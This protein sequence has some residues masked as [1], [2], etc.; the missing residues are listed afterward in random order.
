MS[1]AAS[2]PGD[3]W[4]G[5]ADD[6]RDDVEETVTA[7]LAGL[8]RARSR[9]LLA[10]LLR[11]HRGALFRVGLLVVVSQAAALA[12]PLLVRLGIDRGIPP[13][14]PG[15]GGDP[16]AL[17]VVVA[18]L[19][20]V[21]VIQAV[22]FRAFFFQSGRIGEDVVLSLRGRLYDHVGRLSLSFHERFTSGRVIARLT[23]DVE[24]LGELMQEGLQALVVAALSVVSIGA[25]LVVL[26]P[27]LGLISLAS[28]VPLFAATRWY[29][30]SA[31]RAYR[32]IREAVA[33]V[34]M[35]FVESL[36]GIR[37]VHAFRRE[38]RNQE[39]FSDLN[40]RYREA[41]AVSWRLA[42]VYGP[43]LK[44][45]GHLTTVAVLAY[46]AV[47]ATEGSITV[48]TLTAFLLYL[49]RY[50]DPMQD[51]SQFYTVFQSAAAA[52]EKISG[53]LEAEPA[54]GE[55][56]EPATLPRPA[57]GAT[58][59]AVTFESVGFAYRPGRPVLSGLDLT[60]P[61]G[62]TVALVGETGA[63]KS[64]VA[65]LL[66]RF[67]DPTAGR[68]TLDGVDLRRLADADLRRA[69]VIVTQEGFLFSGSVADNIAL[70]RPDVTRHDVEAAAIAVGA[71]RF[72]AA[73]PAGYDTPVGK[74]GGSLSAG[75]RQL[76]AFA[77]AFLAD[78]RVLILDEATSSLDLPTERTV[79]AA[80]GRLLAGR[81]AVVI[82]HRLSTLAI[83]DRI[84]VME[85]GR[86]VEDGPP[87]DLVAAGGRYAE[88]HAAWRHSL[89]QPA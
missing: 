41:N 51:L 69:V 56:T 57:A 42:A 80:L 37:A 46:G 43:G 15:G 86:I 84:L 74:R 11:P 2:R 21:A 58:G 83:A 70:G 45:L 16:T 60:I 1:A 7:G 53:V 49:R 48:G 50:F 76:V 88:L 23:S 10:D 12:G 47:R 31:E 62:Q 89:A 59:G 40:E 8:F 24:S 6:D 32:A 29:R 82:A 44:L 55:P 39:I 25:V 17:L 78:P 75:Q 20:A 65:R 68:V 81:T 9:R 5:I 73:L 66:A 63:G 35:F 72:I 30:R 61:P 34:I 26:D 85:G 52:L 38:G 87:A 33:L 36:S 28:L 27:P 14:L 77:R 64:S 54:V 18:A 22:T 19:G 4:R 13:L 3:S 71:H 67:W 79:Q